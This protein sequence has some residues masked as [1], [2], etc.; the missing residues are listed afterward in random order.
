MTGC[1]SDTLGLSNSVSELL[2]AGCNSLDCPYKVISS[3]DMLACVVEGNQKLERIRKEK[4]EK[5][6]QLG[7]EEEAVMFGND[8][9]G[10]FPSIT[11]ARTGKIVR[12]K[13]EVSKLK[14]EGM[15]FKR[16]SLYVSLNQEK[17]GDLKE[18]KRYFPWRRKTGGTAPGMNNVEVNSRDKMEDSYWVWPDSEPTARHRKMMIAG[19]AEI[20]KRTLFENFMF[21]FGG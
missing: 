11:S 7:D 19:T 4:I 21:S 3:E 1:D 20:G 16:V 12:C 2:E 5:G 10:L 9:V 6:E 17:T 8:V 14:F 18:L 15:K 13:V